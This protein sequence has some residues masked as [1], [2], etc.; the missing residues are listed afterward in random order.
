MPADLA[1]LLN[2]EELDICAKVESLAFDQAGCRMIQKKL[3]D[4]SGDPFQVT[5]FAAALVYVM[6]D[7]LPEVMTN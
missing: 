6:A 5:N 7:I 2:A 3:E 1:E 4:T